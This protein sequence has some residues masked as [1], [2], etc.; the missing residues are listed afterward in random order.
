MLI[1]GTALALIVG[2]GLLAAK[3]GGAFGSSSRVVGNQQPTP[4]PAAPAAVDAAPAP[5]PTL[6]RDAVGRPAPASTPADPFAP[7][8]W[9]A[10]PF[11]TAP[12]EPVVV[13]AGAADVNPAGAP[14]AETL[15]AAL[16][17]LPASGG[18][19]LLR[20]VGPFTL[21]RFDLP[22]DAIVR[23]AADGATDGGP[24]PVVNA[25]SLPPE[26]TAWLRLRGGSL[27]LDGLHLTLPD[28]AVGSGPPALIEAV[29]GTATVRG[30]SATSRGEAV[31]IRAIGGG[32]SVAR[33]LM[34]GAV[35]RGP[36]L[37]AVSLA[38]GPA[39]L[40]AKDCLLVC[41]NGPAIAFAPAPPNLD[42][43]T[44]PR[45][46]PPRG[47]A[48]HFISRRTPV[49]GANAGRP[50]GNQK[51]AA[52]ATRSARFVNCVGVFQRAAAVV[53]PGETGPFAILLDGCA[54]GAAPGSADVPLISPTEPKVEWAVRDGVLAGLRAP[55]DMQANA[56]STGWPGAAVADL[57]AA[58]P[59]LFDPT[60]LGLESE[61]PRNWS[62]PSPA[63]VARAIAATRLPGE[64]ESWSARFP[65][66]AVVEASG[67]RVDD[68]LEQRHP[69][70]TTVVLTGGGRIRLGPVSVVGRSLR[71]VGRAND[72]G[73]VPWIT[74]QTGAGGRPLFEAVG[75]RLELVN[76][77]I[78]SREDG[79]GG[80]PLVSADG[81]ESMVVVRRC[82]LQTG[83]GDAP[84]VR[85]RQGAA[86][87]VGV[88]L[89]G[90]GPTGLV[91]VDGGA[92]SLRRCGLVSP[93]PAVQFGLDGAGAA[94]LAR[95]AIAAGGP[96]FDASAGG[97]A[98]APGDAVAVTD[99][100]LFLP[101]PSDGLERV[102]LS[103]GGAAVWGAA[104]AF[105]PAYDPP[106]TLDDGPPN[107][108][109]GEFAPRTGPTAALLASADRMNWKT[110][111]PEDLL[112]APGSDAATDGLGAGGA[113]GPS[114]ALT[115]L[116][117]S[118]GGNADANRGTG[119]PRRTAPGPDF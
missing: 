32:S 40:F 86:V 88:L 34:D 39:E 46:S 66:G 16:A 26:A 14:R 33:V 58:E 91:E 61:E 49:A 89:T 101:P 18:T 75:G 24:D 21:P 29:G 105:S 7:P 90:E 56:R 10:E 95:C 74:A 113:V 85:D 20:G 107:P 41:G 6:V 92:V 71:I 35:L 19:V 117:I 73:D 104:N 22:D 52:P 78:E 103:A 53:V 42:L 76:L 110:V 97:G 81:A 48:M 70:G 11:P 82:S 109:G 115:V 12:G 62:T 8:A 64:V 93:G 31:M 2:L 67:G 111:E 44:G 30:G 106:A 28:R 57:A 68:V 99:R 94:G 27:T 114:P 38:A 108:T 84:A 100:C 43:P 47:G 1:G 17:G 36:A 50:R 51:K 23:I 15:A 63:A 119:R 25:V 3:F 96:I 54:F 59:A 102:A 69:D 60:A 65:D 4:D 112:P 13:V 55:D 118:S 116:G 45:P 87:L 9:V 72:R 80:G 37:T 98:G 79:T 77:R 5:A 83:S